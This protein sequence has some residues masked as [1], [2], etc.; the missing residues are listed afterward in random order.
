LD[1]GNFLKIEVKMVANE[2]ASF[3]TG[4]LWE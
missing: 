4:R 2:A 1:F 3:A